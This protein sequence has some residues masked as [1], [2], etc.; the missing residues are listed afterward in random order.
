MPTTLTIVDLGLVLLGVFLLQRAFGRKRS[1][2]LPPGPKGLP[3]IGN[4]LD[5]PTA[6]EW[7][8]FATWGERWGDIMSVNLLGQTM[9]ILNSPK[10]AFDMLDKKSSIYSDRPTLTMGGEL[11]GWDRTL[12]LLRYGNVFRETRRLLSQLIGSRKHLEKFHGHLETETRKF[13]YR[14]MRHPDNVGKQVRKTAGAIILMMSH[15]YKIQEEDDP[16]INTVD[17]AVDQFSKS[18]APG[19]FLVDVFPILKYVPAWMPG[20][21]WKQKAAQ[22]RAK[23]EEMCDLP[24]NY[25]KQQMAA[26]TAKPNFVSTA[27]EESEGLER[28]RIVKNAASSLYSGGAD[29]T[30]SAICTFFLAMTCFPEAQKK[31]Q[32]EIDSV[33]GT[34][35]LPTIADRERLPYVNA[36]CKEVLRWNP[37]APLGVPH[38]LSEDDVH[39]GY[40]IPKDSIVIANI[41]K[42]L[43][44]SQLYTNPFEFNP[45]RFIAQPG[46][47][48]EQDP[49]DF[50][51]GF[52]RRICPGLYLADTSV[53]LSCA[54]SLAAFNIS[55]VVED[56]KAIEPVIE[57]SSGTISHPAPFPCSI[58]PRSAKAE[59]L[60]LHEYA[61]SE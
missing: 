38:R 55:K 43:H 15:G 37:V 29:T 59:S 40:F 28:E 51:F 33:I 35:R 10:L 25:T 9:V 11:A 7:E 26:G 5:M 56:G 30:V 31:A 1:G 12:A 57:Y 53:F 41:W 58:K 36:L 49:R 61:E 6:H 16:I 42:F 50:V 14:L 18:T 13:L 23:I 32:E 48:I 8:T 4:V 24:F 19:A 44:D 21:A 3:V 39:D 60:I 45:D 34:D 20:T 46:K 2:P 27:L 17:E 52:G 54:M 47:E 22:W